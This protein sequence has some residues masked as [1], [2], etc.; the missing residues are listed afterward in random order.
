MAGRN[1]SLCCHLVWGMEVQPTRKRAWEVAT[2]V[3]AAGMWAGKC[4][5]KG[6][7]KGSGW[8]EVQR[9][10][11]RERGRKRKLQEG[12]GEKKKKKVAGC[13]QHKP[14]LQLPTVAFQPPDSPTYNGFPATTLYRQQQLYS[15][16]LLVVANLKSGFLQ[17]WL[18]SQHKIKNSATYN[19][20]L[21]S[22][23]LPKF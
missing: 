9:K 23:T 3:G 1:L 11:R 17:R 7:Q 6:S 14:P 19:L 15:L 16:C 2:G 8:E 12:R 21:A 22:S 5:K 10:E 18:F 4:N 13:T 20:P